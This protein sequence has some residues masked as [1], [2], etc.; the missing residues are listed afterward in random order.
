MSVFERILDINAERSGLV[1]SFREIGY[2]IR[3]HGGSGLKQLASLGLPGIR[4]K[5]PIALLTAD[6]E[7]LAFFVRDIMARRGAAVTREIEA[8]VAALE[9]PVPE[10]SN[11]RPGWSMR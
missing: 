3:F 5:N 6:A 2:S 7:R 9:P 11:G 4:S 8:T 10:V 1:L